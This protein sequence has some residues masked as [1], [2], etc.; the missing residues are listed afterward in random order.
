MGAL[1]WEPATVEVVST[2]RLEAGS[3]QE[4][5]ARSP[6][7]GLPGAGSV[8][9]AALLNRVPSGPNSKTEPRTDVASGSPALALV[10]ATVIVVSWVNAPGG[11]VRVASPTVMA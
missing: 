5:T 9:V 2:Q 6:E 1:I 8:S 3:S 11:M 10:T 7:P 4:M